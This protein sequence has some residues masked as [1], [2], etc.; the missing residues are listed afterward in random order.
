MFDK[1]KTIIGRNSPSLKK[2]VK[3]IEILL[4]GEDA[5]PESSNWSYKDIR[6]I[7]DKTDLVPNMSN[8]EL[9][10]IAPSYMRIETLLDEL[11]KTDKHTGPQTLKYRLEIIEGCISIFHMSHLGH[12]NYAEAEFRG[13]HGYNPSLTDENL[14]QQVDGIQ[15]NLDRVKKLIENAE[16]TISGKEAMKL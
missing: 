8:Q 13:M 3:A 14:R 16:F 5:E 2:R 15:K 7:L 1:L 6:E 9:Q 10:N 11:G 4:E 12:T